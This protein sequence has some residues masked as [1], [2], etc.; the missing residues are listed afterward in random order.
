MV[1]QSAG[2]DRMPMTGELSDGVLSCCFA[3]TCWHA[4][5]LLGAWVLWSFYAGHN[6]CLPNLALKLASVQEKSPYVAAHEAVA[7]MFHGL[8]TLVGGFLF[9]W[10]N[11]GE[12]PGRFGLAAISPYTAI[13][14]LALLLRLLAVPLAMAI[15]E[16]GTWKW[17]EICA[18]SGIAASASSEGSASV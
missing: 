13:F 2:I 15:H 1:R 16:P 10:L 7:S 4:W 11:D 8:I 14:G 5:I 12:A 9:D 6:I 3:D 17:R 18:Q